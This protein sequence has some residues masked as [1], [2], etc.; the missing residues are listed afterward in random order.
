MKKALVKLINWLLHSTIHQLVQYFWVF[1]VNSFSYFMEYFFFSKKLFPLVSS[2][3]SHHWV[4]QI[5]YFCETYCGVFLEKY[6]SYSMILWFSLDKLISL[7]VEELM[8]SFLEVIFSFYFLFFFIQRILEGFSRIYLSIIFWILLWILTS[9]VI[10]ILLWVL[11][12]NTTTR[13]P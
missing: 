2:P 13:K 1:I 3:L 9:L 10:W 8:I 12:W 6:L 11:A 7:I 5:R 4:N